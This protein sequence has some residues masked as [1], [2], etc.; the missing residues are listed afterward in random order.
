MLRCTNQSDGIWAK[1]PN[2]FL[3]GSFEWQEKTTALLRWTK[4][5]LPM[6]NWLNDHELY[7][8]EDEMLCGCCL[9]AKRSAVFRKHLNFRSL[10]LASW[11]RFPKCL[12]L[13]L[14]IA[15]RAT[16][17]KL[18]TQIVANSKARELHSLHEV[19]SLELTVWTSE[20]GSHILNLIECAHHSFWLRNQ[21]LNFFYSWTFKFFRWPFNRLE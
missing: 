13:T 10:R 18:G 7:S 6:P 11:T 17:R 16:A 19:Q 3:I 15:Q 12:T 21:S 9:G 14:L 2:F 4:S 20:S 1:F 8:S 5:T